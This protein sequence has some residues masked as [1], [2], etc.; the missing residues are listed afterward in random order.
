MTFFLLRNEPRR[1][2]VQLSTEQIRL[3]LV[4]EGKKVKN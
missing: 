4:E 3:V 2:K 1:V